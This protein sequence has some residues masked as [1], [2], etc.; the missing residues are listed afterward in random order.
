MILYHNIK[1]SDDNRKVRQFP[2]F[3]NTF[4]QKME[5]VAKDLQIHISDVTSASK[6][7]RGGG[8][9]G[10]KEGKA[11]DRIRKRMIED[12]QKKIKCCIRNDKLGK[13]QYI[14][15]CESNSLKYNKK[16]QITN[17]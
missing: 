10:G 4:Y 5:K 12:V 7:K 9:G 3:Q 8:G 11:I 13:K 16:N 17:V 2:T 6:S 1:S 14:K 15:K